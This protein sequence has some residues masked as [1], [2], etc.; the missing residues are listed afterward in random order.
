MKVTSCLFCQAPDE[1]MAPLYGGVQGNI[2][3]E[4][5]SEGL[6]HVLTRHAR[7]SKVISLQLKEMTCGFCLEPSDERLGFVKAEGAI[8]HKCM[9]RGA[10]LSL[11]EDNQP[12]LRTTRKESP[13]KLLRSFF[14]ENPNALV[15]SSRQYSLQLEADFQLAL[16]HLLATQS[17]IHKLVGVHSRYGHEGINFPMLLTDDQYGPCLGPLRYKDLDVGDDAPASCLKEGLWL[18][19]AD[20]MRYAA[21]LTPARKFGQ[22]SG[23]MLEFAVPDGEQGR[24]LVEAHFKA[25]AEALKKAQTYRGKVLSLEEVEH[26]EGTSAGIHVHKLKDVAREEV[27]LPEQTLALLERNVFQFVEQREELKNFALST[28]KGLLFYGPPGTGKT[29]TIHYLA[30]RLREHTFLLVT[31]GQVGLLGEYM[32]LARL[33]QPTV[34]VLEDADL[35]A[36]QRERMDSPC[37]EVLL[38]QLLNEMDGL[39]EDA[40]ILFILTTNRPQALEVALAGRPGRVDQAIEF[41]LPDTRGREHLFRLYAR[42]L[43]ISDE[44]RASIVQ[45]TEGVSAAFIKELMRRVAQIVIAAQRK[46][47]ITQ[48]D[49]DAALDEMLHQGG[50]LNAALLGVA[51]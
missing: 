14:P 30:T 4:C 50:S 16:T 35:I 39:R 40:E 21:L 25:I 1:G 48:A 27:I 23:V 38:N 46:D 24:V 15:T 9:L 12:K 49:F 2:C 47:A 18:L 5:L 32:S 36:R 11:L 44:L 17:T 20:G 43:D 41:P 6:T 51:S 42:G 31:A 10:E 37:E 33:L 22:V 45:K 34:V 7:R 19:E 26:H 28:K 13:A 3:S 8:C 29:H